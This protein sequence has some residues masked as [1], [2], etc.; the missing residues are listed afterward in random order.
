MFEIY[1]KIN[2]IYPKIIITDDNSNVSLNNVENE[3]NNN[4]GV[5]P[6]PS[7]TTTQYG[8][9]SFSNLA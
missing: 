4:Y 7:G 5:L 6:P 8:E 9:S 1:L 3:N 2:C